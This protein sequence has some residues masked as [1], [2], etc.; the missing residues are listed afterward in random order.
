MAYTS[1]KYNASKQV[2]EISHRVF[3]DDFEATLGEKYDYRNGD[4]FL[5]QKDA[6]TQKA[7]DQFFGKNFSMMANSTNLKLKYIKTE[8]KNQMGI[9]VHYETQKV[10]IAAIK[11]ITI[12]NFIMMESFKEQ[13]NMFNLNINDEIKRT[14]KFEIG[15]TKETLKIK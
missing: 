5:K 4:V 10:N 8:Q 3:Q 6:A 14:L 11:T 2:F 13:V 7:V 9:I 1:V 12:Y 15:K